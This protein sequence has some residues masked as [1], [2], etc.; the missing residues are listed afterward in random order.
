MGWIAAARPVVERLIR[1]G[2]YL[3]P[4]LMAD[5]LQEVGE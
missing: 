5:A 2:L 3:S 4:S 1:D